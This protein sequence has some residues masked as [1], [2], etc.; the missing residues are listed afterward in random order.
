MLSAGLALAPGASAELEAP[1]LSADPVLDG[2][3][4]EDAWSDAASST[5]KAP[6]TGESTVT[7]G[8]LDDT[9]ELALGFELSDETSR[10][11]DQLTVIIAP[12]EVEDDDATESGDEK[13]VIDANGNWERYRYSSNSSI[14]FQSSPSSSGD[15][16]S[17]TGS[18]W[19]FQVDRSPSDAWIVEMTIDVGDF[20]AGDTIKLALSQKDVHGSGDDDEGTV[21]RPNGYEEAKPDGWETTTLTG[22]PSDVKLEIRPATVEAAVGG[23]VIVTLPADTAGGNLT[24]SVKA[25]GANEFTSLDTLT[26]GRAGTN[27]FS[28][29]P[30]AAGTYQVQAEWQG[31]AN[32]Q[33]TTVGPESIEVARPS[34]QGPTVLE[35]GMLRVGFPAEAANASADWSYLGARVWATDEADET[36]A[37]ARLDSGNS[38]LDEATVAPANL[39]PDG[40]ALVLHL[41]P[42]VERAALSMISP[43]DGFTASWEAYTEDDEIAASGTAEGACGDPVFASIGDADEQVS[44]IE[45]SYSG[46]DTRE[47]LDA[48]FARPVETSPYVAVRADPSPL[49]PDGIATLVAS[50]GSP[51]EL[52]RA[53]VTV[54]AGG[55][56]IGQRTCDR[57]SGQ[58]WIDCPVDARL[59]NGTGSVKVTIDTKDHAGTP[60]T[61][62]K[63]LKTS[64]DHAPPT[65]SLLPRPMLAPPGGAVAVTAEATDGSGVANITMTA[66]TGAGEELASESCRATTKQLVFECTLTVTPSGSQTTYVTADYTDRA[67]NSVTVGPKPLPVR[68]TDTDG[69]GLPDSLESEL[70]TSPTDAD[71]D[72][73]GLSDGWE[74]VGVDRSGDGQAELDL[75]ALGADPQVKDLFLEID[76]AR[77]DGHTHEPA[78]SALQLVRNVFSAQGIR[79]HTDIQAAGDRYDPARFDHGHAAHRHLMSDARSGIYMHVLAGHLG[80]PSTGGGNTIYLSTTETSDQVAGRVGAH[81]LHEIGH[82]LGL[83]H[84]GGGTT[85]ED[86]TQQAAYAENYKPNYLSV[87]NDAYAWGI[88]VD[89]TNGL[90]RV[91]TL[92]GLAVGDLDEAA[93]DE[94]DGVDFDIPTLQSSLKAGPTPILEEDTITG[95]RLRYTCPGDGPTRWG[96]APGPIDW[97][98]DGSSGDTGVTADINRGGENG[99]ESTLVSRTDW[100]ALSFAGASCPQYALMLTDEADH[101]ANASDHG[102]AYQ[103]LGLA[104]CPLRPAPATPLD[105]GAE[106]SATAPGAPAGEIKEADRDQDVDDGFADADGDNV[107]NLLDDC[108]T[109]ADGGQ[110]DTDGDG[111]G[112]RCQAPPVRVSDA[113]AEVET[114]TGLVRLSWSPIS[115]MWGYNVYKLEG[116][117]VT[118]LGGGFPSTTSDGITDPAGS[119]DDRYM[120]AAVNTLADQGPS[121]TVTPTAADPS[122]GEDDGTDTPDEG[123]P[124]PGAL[125]ALAATTVAALLAARR[126]R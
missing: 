61:A 111:R 68:S 98:C 114:D 46:E 42:P 112:D 43:E 50:A 7:L 67:G 33:S 25:P 5:F 71:T 14:G 9:G 39:D 120:I 73:D 82:Q 106:S 107:V 119:A 23:D 115:D 41:D 17:S 55:S 27:T 97:N 80:G 75:A 35:T 3:L 84:G 121:V 24:A 36:L 31:D 91:P 102:G 124:G 1:T 49:H 108:P 54:T 29:T 76:S 58:V 52:T 109:V 63:T 65:P 8:Y 100:E 66:R 116:D 123:V 77:H 10:T 78:Y 101:A 64:A 57:P 37:L 62:T 19:S 88:I 90:V 38:C 105:G 59:P 79:V 70:G 118:R 94:P 74:V 30:E 48:V 85:G 95:L 86:G 126:R 51:D 16:P 92:A 113:S 122:D 125:A 99:G 32:Y 110:L 6:E 117:N 12:R 34:Q 44:R 26:P 11:D 60:T 81:L 15:D 45:I 13:F 104:P 56:T 89:T 47:V 69:D 20:E 22:R 2:E 87:M 4:D 40:G 72:G 96:L 103:P 53:T 21:K 18:A 83:G 28:W 93:L